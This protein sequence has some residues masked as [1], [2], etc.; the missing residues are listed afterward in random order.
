LRVINPLP[1]SLFT[2]IPAFNGILGQT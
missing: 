1:R 2:A